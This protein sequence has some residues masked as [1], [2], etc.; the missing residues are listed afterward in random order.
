MVILWLVACQG[1]FMAGMFYGKPWVGNYQE[2]PISRETG[3]K[4]LSLRNSRV[5]GIS[6][7]LGNSCAKANSSILKAI[8]LSFD[9]QTVF[10]KI[11]LKADN[12]SLIN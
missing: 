12:F 9:V 4:S 3:G 2:I 10:L 1:G 7:G 8:T 5:M 6:R 11:H